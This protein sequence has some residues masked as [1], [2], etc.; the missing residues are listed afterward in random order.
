MEVAGEDL[1]ARRIFVPRGLL[2]QEHGE[3]VGLLARRAPDAPHAHLVAAV[4]AR[5][6]LRD[7][8]LL[9]LREDL[10]VAEEARH[11]HEEIVGERRKLFRLLAEKRQ[12]CGEVVDLPQLHAACDPPQDGGALVAPEV[13]AGASAQKGEDRLEE[14]LRLVFGRCI[15][16]RSDR[17]LARGEAQDGRR[18]LAEREH[19]VH[20]A[21]G[22]R[23]ERHPVVVGVVGRLHDREAALLSDRLHAERAV[24]SGPAEDDAHGVSVVGAREGAKEVVDRGAVAAALLERRQAEVRVDRFE[25]GVRRDDVDAIRLER[26]GLLHG[27]HREANVRL[28]ELGEVALVVGR[29]MHDHDEGEPAVLRQ[30]GEEALE[31]G[32]PACRR[33]D[34]HHR[35]GGGRG[36]GRLAIGRVQSGP[37][38]WNGDRS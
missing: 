26:D 25:I 17:R 3:G 1:N 38:R 14:S 32:E 20:Q 11:R 16:P 28:E 24:A 31:R 18:D 34:P 27:G 7:D 37:S 5:E 22:D 10:R 21:R 36:H 15:A 12:V 19:D 30:P 9:E 33:T 8:V 23:A 4:L 13:A 6:E 35:E 29:E 2:E